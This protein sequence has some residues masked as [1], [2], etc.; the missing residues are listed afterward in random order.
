VRDEEGVRIDYS[1]KVGLSLPIFSA[2]PLARE[3]MIPKIP[4]PAACDTTRGYLHDCRVTVSYRD[5][6]RVLVVDDQA[7]I[8]LPLCDDLREAGFTVSAAVSVEDAIGAARA[9]KPHVVVLDMLLGT[10]SGLEVA[11]SLRTESGDSQ[12]LII[13]LSG[14][15]GSRFVRGAGEAGCDF[16]LAKTSPRAELIAAIDGLLGLS[17][18]SSPP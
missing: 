2:H 7:S 11:R 5:G 18:A 16:Y 6:V 3:N 1:L 10:K 15:T 8:R 12:P 9:R 17:M 4:T 13:A 14:H